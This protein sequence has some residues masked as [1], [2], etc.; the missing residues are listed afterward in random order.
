[1]TGIGG[2]GVE[3]DGTGINLMVA[4]TSETSGNVAGGGGGWTAGGP[5]AGG[6]G[7]WRGVSSAADS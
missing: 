1:M 3:G 4:A 7:A 6:N 5:G 2:G